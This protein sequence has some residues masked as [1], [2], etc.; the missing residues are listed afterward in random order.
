MAEPKQYSFTYISEKH[1]NIFKLLALGYQ[2][3]RKASGCDFFHSMRWTALHYARNGKGRLFIG[4]RK[5][6]VHAGDF[7]LIPA[8]V[9]TKYYPDKADPWRYFW[10]CF[11]EDSLF[12]ANSSLGLSENEP[13]RHAASPQTVTALFDSLFEPNESRTDLYYK[14]LVTL[15]EIMRSEHSQS[16]S[17][18]PTVAGDEAAERIK[19]I[20]DLNYTRPDFSIHHISPMLYTS[21]RHLGRIFKT[22]TGTTPISYLM[23]LR[24][25]HAAELLRERDYSVRELAE[26]SGFD[27]EAY[28]MRCFKKNFGMTIKEYRR[29]H[30]DENK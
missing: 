1:D 2:D 5:Y 29:T 9:N 15:M 25:E 27:N 8:N 12:D 26:N 10:I 11:S 24:L 3:Y 13:V 23:K 20:I 30:A 16:T 7:F 4:D 6:R 19:N 14:T 17:P 18:L 22:E 28:F 21:Q